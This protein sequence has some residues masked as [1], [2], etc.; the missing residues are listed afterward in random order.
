M[1]IKPVIRFFSRY[2]LPAILLGTFAVPTGAGLAQTGEATITGIR[3]TVEQSPAAAPSQWALA[4]IKSLLGI[5]DSVRTGAD[6]GAELAY[7][8][9]TLFRLAPTTT[10]TLQQKENR[11]LKLLL[12]KFWLKHK[13]GAGT[14][15]VQTPS[16]VASITSQEELFEVDSS[17]RTRV[18]V[19]ETD[20]SAPV[21]VQGIDAGGNPVGDPINLGSGQAL[22]VNPGGSAGTPVQVDVNAER[23][24]NAIL[25]SPAFEEAVK[26]VSG[27]LGT[28]YQELQEFLNQV[29]L[30]ILRI[31]P[32]SLGSSPISSDV[33][34]EVK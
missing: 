15:K 16:V 2:L 19:L 14:I 9:G 11:I 1:K 4:R 20:P 18:V 24:A 23:S 25:T 29:Q 33:E 31:D 27:V 22:D 26:E 6:S 34:V 10:L 32:Q 28:A 17:G 30:D 5:G 8:D 21:V 3:K 7:A 13:K 12:G